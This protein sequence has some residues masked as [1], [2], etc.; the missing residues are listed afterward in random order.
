M[1]CQI[2]AGMCNYITVIN[3]S[4]KFERRIKINKYFSRNGVLEVLE[5]IVVSK[6][7]NLGDYK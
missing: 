2:K 6:Y 7:Y 5:K 3:H 1:A 4:I